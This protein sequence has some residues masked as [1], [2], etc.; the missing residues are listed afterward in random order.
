MNVNPPD[1]V[2]YQREESEET[3]SAIA[4]HVIKNCGYGN[5]HPVFFSVHPELSVSDG[6]GNYMYPRA[7]SGGDELLL[8]VG[9]AG[10]KQLDRRMGRVPANKVKLV[11]GLGMGC[12]HVHLL[13]K[14]K[15]SHSRF[16]VSPGESAVFTLSNKIY[17]STARVMSSGGLLSEGDMAATST[18]LSLYGVASADVYMT[19]GGPGPNAKGFSFSMENV[20]PA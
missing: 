17:V 19:G 5:Y 7:V 18:E 4:W 9:S 2:I 11:N 13:R 6:Y 8:T 3:D 16:N 10:N 12:V 14:G 1:V 15:A 20:V